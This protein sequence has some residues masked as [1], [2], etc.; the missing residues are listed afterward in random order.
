MLE[1]VV[2]VV[3]P[4]LLVAVFTLALTL[5]IRFLLEATLDVALLSKYW[6]RDFFGNLVISLICLGLTHSTVRCL[7]LSTIAITLL[8]LSNALKLTILG[9]PISPDDFINVK[10]LFILWD[11]VLLWVLIA[12]AVL[13]AL[14]MVILTR[15]RRPLSWLTLGIV[16]ACVPLGVLYSAELKTTLDK[17]FGNSVWNQPENFRKR[18]LGL[19]IVQETVRTISKVGDIPSAEAVANV[20]ID[21]TFVQ[22]EILEK[23]KRN[24]H[25]I[26]LESFFD[27]N[28]L[29]KEWVPEDPFPKE[30]TR[31]WDSTGRSQILAP[32]FGGYTANAEFES[33]CGFP[34]TENAV[35]FE[36]WLRRRAPCLPEVLSDA[37]YQSIASHPNVAGFWN[38]THA[39]NLIGFDEY[40]NKAHF[41]TSDSV[42]NFVLDHSFFEQVFDRLEQRDE[43]PIF[44]YML[45][46]FGHL[47]YPLNDN[48]PAVIKTGKES[49]LLEGYLNHL[50]YKTR[51]L[52]AMLE[53]LR[54]QD[55]TALIV[56]FGDH[57][58][59]LG[60]NY[61][62]YTDTG[63]MMADRDDFTPEMFHFLASTPLIV[64]DG[65]KG[66]L[67]TGDMPLYRLPAL[68]LSLLKSNATGAL[69]WTTNPPDKIIRPIYGMHFYLD[70]GEATTCRPD[71][72]SVGDCADT[73]QWLDDVKTLSADIFT[74][75][76]FSLKEWKKRAQE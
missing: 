31:L 52:M 43:R 7:V 40:W 34:V 30:F 62:V 16:A 39:Y 44:N 58:P 19:H 4:L 12:L 53:Q 18:G 22:P 9:T 29:G 54:E 35:F 51:D 28:S 33:L 55:P 8:Q 13:P 26:V 65:E 5:L 69:D 73:N 17:R 61:G 74:G 32:V 41:D 25:M 57:L 42:G 14:L 70:D 59:N 24:L 72:L 1:N 67:K 11:G 46:L 36:G 47:P 21:L 2:K 38:R 45:T 76:Q 50:Y 23:P 3:K 49:K 64:I 48:Y 66:V 63:K 37:G 20:N 56:I 60:K 6:H 15:W 10:N 75:K 27:P 71:N 68:I